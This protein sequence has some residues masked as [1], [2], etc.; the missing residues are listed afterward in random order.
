MITGA[1]VTVLLLALVHADDTNLPAG[2]GNNPR[3]NPGEK[4]FSSEFRFLIGLVV[5]R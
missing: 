5:W 1:I 2:K 3:A 4:K